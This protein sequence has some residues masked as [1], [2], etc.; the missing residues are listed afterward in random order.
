MDY[1][2]KFKDEAEANEVLKDYT[3]DIDV[4][5]VMY[6]PATVESE[7]YYN[8]PGRTELTPRIIRV[9]DPIPIDGW[10]VN[11]RGEVCPELESYALDLDTPRR[12][13]Y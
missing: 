4:I 8:E 5:G 7:V 12:V 6:H 9:N 10:H 3:G 11:V 13:W 2:L 1:Y